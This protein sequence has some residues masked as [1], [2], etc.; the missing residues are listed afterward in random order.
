M[1]IIFATNNNNKVKEI[2]SF[3]N[4]SLKII[5]L[6]EADIFE[7]IEEP[8]FTFEEN[9]L[10]KAMYVY[11][12]TGKRCFSEDSGI[13]VEALNGA[14]GVLSA[15]YA[16]VQGDDAANNRKLLEALEKVEDRAAYYKAVICLVFNLDEIIYFDGVC[17]GKIATELVGNGGF[18][19]DPLFI[20]EGYTTTFGV[21]GIDI[22]KQLSHRSKAIE[23]MLHYLNKM[24]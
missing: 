10:T 3:V 4:D 15:R 11:K 21:L 23:K 13:V 18:G 17:K 24:N 5:S 8:Y 19:Y 1:E 6:K 12:K 20:P 9:A 22:K 16:G 2:Q 14:P 7:E